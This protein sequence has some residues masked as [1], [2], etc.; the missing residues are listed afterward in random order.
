MYYTIYAYENESIMHLIFF[1]KSTLDT[2]TYWAKGH[3]KYYDKVEIRVGKQAAKL[4]HVFKKN[5]YHIKF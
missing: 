3:C 4:K 5:G 2:V 1:G